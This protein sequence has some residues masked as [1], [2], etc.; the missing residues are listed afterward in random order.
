[1]TDNTCT[2]RHLLLVDDEPN[3]VRALVRILRRD[4]YQ[5]HTANSGKEGLELLQDH[6]VGVIISDQRM[7]EMNGIEF[8]SQV[9]ELYPDTIRIVL[10]GYTDLKSVT[11]AINHG[12]IY[13]FLTKPWEDDLLRNNIREA[14]EQHELV[15]KNEYLSKKLEVTNKEL[16]I[17]NQELLK[18]VERK[19]RYANHNMIS[20]Q[21]SQDVLENLPMGVTGIGDD[22]VIALA[23]LKAHELI[24]PGT[25]SLIGFPVE[26]VLPDNIMSIYNQTVTKDGITTERIELNDIGLVD[27]IISRLG[28]A[29]QSKGMVMLITP[30]GN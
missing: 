17:A 12:S 25:G 22:G 11:D 21:V 4:G 8:L 6:T 14:F 23:N 5:I 1:M 27:L 18:H 20:L 3:I 9:K 29:S 26:L 30:V 16:I 15:S 2:D 10:S 19:S 13:K 24:K 7:P 28:S